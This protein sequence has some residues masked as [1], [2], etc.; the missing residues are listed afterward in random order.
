MVLQAKIFGDLPD[1]FLASVGSSLAQCRPGP[2]QTSLDLGLDMQRRKFKRNS[3]FLNEKKWIC[4]CLMYLHAG[5]LADTALSTST[6]ERAGSVF[7]KASWHSGGF[8]HVEAK[9]WSSA[10]VDMALSNSL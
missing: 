7:V 1:P 8:L 6:G 5:L 4:K 3:P 10:E 2:G 9:A